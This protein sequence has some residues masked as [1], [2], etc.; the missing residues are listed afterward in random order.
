MTLR[1]WPWV[2][3]GEIARSE[4]VERVWRPRSFRLMLDVSVPEVRAPEVWKGFTDRY[5]RPVDGSGVAIAVID[6]GIDYRHPDFSFPNG[7]TR[8]LAIWDQTVEGRPP[9]GFSYG[10]ECLRSEI[11]DESCPE[12]DGMG[13]GTHVAS[14]AAGAGRVGPYKGVAPGAYL[15]VVKSGWPVCGGAQWFMREDELIDAMRYAA[16]KARE[17]GL[18]LVINLSLGSDIGGHDGNSPMERVIE[19]LAEEGVVVVVAAGNSAADRIHAMGDLSEVKEFTLNWTIPP[20]TTGFEVSFLLDPD[21]DVE[22]EL[23]TPYGSTSF[24]A[25]LGPISANISTNTYEIGRELLIEVG[26]RDREERALRLSPWAL[27]VRAREITGE[28]VWH[29]WISSDTCSAM[30]EHFLKSEGYN[31][32]ESYTVSVPATSPKAIAVGAYATRSEWRTFRGEVKRIWVEPGELLYFSGRGPTRDGRVKPDIVAPGSLIVA[33]KPVGTPLS[34]LDVSEYY[35]VKQGTS[36]SAPHVAGAVALLLQ[37]FPEASFEDVYAALTSAARWSEGMGSRPSNDWGWGK[38]NAQAFYRLVVNVEGLPQEL[39]ATIAIDDDILSLPGG[40]SLEKV[41]L[42]GKAYNLSAQREIMIGEGSRYRLKNGSRIFE[43]EANLTLRYVL[44]HLLVV[45]SE[46]GGEIGGGW[47]PKGA[48][49]RFSA[50]AYST[51]QGLEILF[52]PSISLKGWMDEDGKLLR[53]P[54]ILMDKP[55]IVTAVYEVD[56]GVMAMGWGAVASAGAS[57][58]LIVRRVYS[59]RARSVKKT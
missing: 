55:H 45:R 50:R 23:L 17:L 49:A 47:Y 36:M 51:P 7:S 13:H 2:R 4:A 56:Y 44:E 15:I 52:K 42:R 25:T 57:A 41:F 14:I 38:L 11:E 33:A 18:R 58:A 34:V 59:K 5:G 10:H 29:A 28:A 54:E 21:D 26:L 16:D 22:M 6:T 19:A 40:G 53:K 48:L 35:A 1:P 39:N 9:R 46:L 31:V 12:F 8:I 32:T 24:N 37:L 27:R 3:D 30:R 43:N 20:R